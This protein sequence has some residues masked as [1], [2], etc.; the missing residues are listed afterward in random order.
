MRMKTMKKYSILLLALAALTA[1]E[2]PSIYE[3]IEFQVLLSPENTY[4]V[5]DPV[6]FEFTGNP[7]YILFYSGETGHEYQYRN[8]TSVD[9][10]DIESCELTL[11]LNARSGSEAC[12][13]A[14]I[15]NQFGGLNGADETAD[16][17]LIE[18]LIDEQGDLVGWQKLEVV[19]SKEQQKWQ[20]TIQDITLLADNF[21]LALRW[22]PSS[23]ET[24]Q[25]S[26]WVSSQ[27][28]VRFKGYD[29]QYLNSKALNYIPFEMSPEAE[30]VTKTGSRYVLTTE[31]SVAG[32]VRYHPNKTGLNS[33]EM[34][35]T[36]SGKYDANNAKTLPYVIDTYL[37]T[38]PM[39]LNL[40][41]PDTGVSIKSLNGKLAPY[42]HT[43]TEP[44]TYTV[45]F[46]GTT[47]NYLDTSREVK[48]FTI[49]IIE[50][51]AE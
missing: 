24:S 28:K 43:F 11:Q 16:K 15:T 41:E 33:E 25:R 10:N 6:T 32:T 9:P 35:M 23:T 45:T 2:H 37:F 29:T 40:I 21:S 17:A 48:E 20:T 36:G 39:A 1:C 44:G 46:V 5:G 31:S 34:I 4:R 14:Y 26:Y 8:R 3:P 47:G 38:T 22:H 19:D 12:V 42:Q 30:G 18:S 13:S 50:P 7:D 27:V 49:T 51:L